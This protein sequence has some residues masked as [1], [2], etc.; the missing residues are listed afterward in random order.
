MGNFRGSRRMWAT[1]LPSFIGV[2]AALNA[3]LHGHT[4]NRAKPGIEAK[5]AIDN[6]L[7]HSWHQLQ[8]GEYH[9]QGDGNI[10]RRHQ[11]HSHLSKVSDT[12]HTTDNN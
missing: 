12:L 5:G 1:T 4:D 7:N 9:K 2:D 6:Q 11:W 10:T 3:P 8:V